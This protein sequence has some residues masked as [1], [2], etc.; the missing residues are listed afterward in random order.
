MKCGFSQTLLYNLAIH[1]W[2]Y[3]SCLIGGSHSNWR[4]KTLIGDI[5][6]HTTPGEY[7]IWQYWDQ[8]MSLLSRDLL[9]NMGYL[10]RFTSAFWNRLVAN[11]LAIRVLPQ[12]S[13]LL[14]LQ[15]HFYPH[16]LESI[17]P[18]HMAISIGGNPFPSCTFSL[19][20]CK[21]RS[22]VQLMYS[23]CINA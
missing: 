3:I 15:W 18:A 14:N 13:H 1:W 7:L 11:L 12:M 2:W 9:W 20:F 22:T 21:C 4:R 16:Y 5:C 8:K 23:A 19:I 10:K 6:G 17:Q